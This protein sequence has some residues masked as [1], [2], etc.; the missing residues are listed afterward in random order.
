M[1]LQ[2][3]VALELLKARFP[4]THNDESWLATNEGIEC[5]NTAN[6][7]ATIAIGAIQEGMPCWARV[8]CWQCGEEVDP[9]SAEKYI[10]RNIIRKLESMMCQ[11]ARDDNY[12]C[13]GREHADCATLE[14]LIHEYR[15]LL[16]PLHHPEDER[17]SI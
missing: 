10:Y 6:E 17:R 3:H 11:E 9:S 5:F 8:N 1:T 16:E 12:K 2:N 14:L 4:E 13:E 15:Q 7:E